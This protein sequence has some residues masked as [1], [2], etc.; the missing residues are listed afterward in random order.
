MRLPY[1]K[2]LLIYIYLIERFFYLALIPQVLDQLV[3]VQGDIP[4]L[5]TVKVWQL[6]SVI[7]P[8]D[9]NIANKNIANAKN[10]CTS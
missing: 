8:N 6:G 2:F 4:P 5:P 1:Y 3:N 9:K 7:T 10:I